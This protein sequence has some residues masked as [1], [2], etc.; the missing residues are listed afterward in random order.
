[1]RESEIVSRMKSLAIQKKWKKRKAKCSRSGTTS[2]SG[3]WCGVEKE[4]KRKN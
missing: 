2:T 1:M 4:R 3:N